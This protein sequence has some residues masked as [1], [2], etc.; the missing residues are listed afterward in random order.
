[1]L[2]LVVLV[3][4]LRLLLVV[5][6]KWLLLWLLVVVVKWLL[7]VRMEVCVEGRRCGGVR[8]RGQVIGESSGSSGDRR[9]RGRRGCRRCRHGQRLRRLAERE[10]V[11]QRCRQLLGLLLLLMRQKHWWRLQR[12]TADDGVGQLLL[13]LVWQWRWLQLLMVMR[14]VQG[15]VHFVGRFRFGG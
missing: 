14:R 13:L 7:L 11:V 3:M 9:R 10:R 15:N 2:L 4:L 1:M 6:M 8:V 12:L 5:M